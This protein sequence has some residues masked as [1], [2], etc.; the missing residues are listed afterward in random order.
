MLGPIDYMKEFERLM[1]ST[2]ERASAA[3]A[4]SALEEKSVRRLMK[5]KRLLAKGMRLGHARRMVI[6]WREIGPC[7]ISDR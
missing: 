2:E 1:A 6:S 7:D 5:N 3:D 4:L